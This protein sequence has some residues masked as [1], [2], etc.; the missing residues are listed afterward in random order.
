ML[1]IHPL[2]I[3]DEIINSEKSVKRRGIN[4]D[5]KQILTTFF[6]LFCYKYM[7]TLHHQK[8]KNKKLD[9]RQ[10]P[11]YVKGAWD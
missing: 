5:N 11:R 7:Y 6:F 2:N 1:S 3:N 8:N 4:V 9:V 10:A